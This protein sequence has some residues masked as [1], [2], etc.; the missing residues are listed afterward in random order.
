M[1]PFAV[2]WSI[3]AEDALAL[4]WLHDS[5]RSALT[6]ATEL[7]ERHLAND[8]FRYGQSIAEG[9]WAIDVPP[10]RL[11]YE[12]DEG[13]RRVEVTGVRRLA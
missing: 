11:Y 5:N 13:N 3:E 8:P 6:L 2:D 10:L 7:A 9:L 12:I 1:N 4:H